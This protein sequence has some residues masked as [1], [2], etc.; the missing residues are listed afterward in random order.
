MLAIR[1]KLR[2]SAFIFLLVLLC[3]A[4][5]YSSQRNKQEPPGAAPEIG[6]LQSAAQIS[7]VQNEHNAF[8][9]TKSNGR[10]VS[11][12]NHT[13]ENGEHVIA[14]DCWENP[15]GRVWFDQEADGYGYQLRF[16]YSGK[17]LEPESE[18]NNAKLVQRTC[19]RGDFLR[20]LVSKDTQLW[21]IS[22]LAGG[23]FALV[24][25]DSGYAVTAVTENDGVS[26][27]YLGTF[28]QSN[29]Q[30]FSY[31]NKVTHA[32]DPKVMGMWGDLIS[33]PFVPIQA[34]ALYDDTVLSWSSNEKDS[35]TTLSSKSSWSSVFDVAT[36]TFLSSNNPTHDMFCSGSVLME[37]GSVLASGGNPRA[38]QTSGFDPLTK[39]WSSL[40]SMRQQRWYG[41]NVL[42][43]RG[44]VLSG[45]AKGAQETPELYTP[46]N[47]TWKDLP[48]A[49]MSAMRDE[50][51]AV[52]TDKSS[53]NFSASMQWY[54]FMHTSPDGRVF[55]SGPLTNFHW[56]STEQSGSTESAGSPPDTSI[57]RQYGSSVMY[58]V[59]KLL[60]SGG[61]DPRITGPIDSGDSEQ[62]LGATDTAYTVEISAASPTIKAVNS[63]HTRRANHDS[64]VLPTG[65]V[66]VV[67][68]SKSGVLF[69]DT[70]TAW[71]SEIWNPQ[72]EQWR[73]VAPISAPRGYHSWALLVRDGRVLAGGGGLCG[74]CPA[75]HSDAQFYYPP[76]LFA[77]NGQASNRPSILSATSAAKVGSTITVSVDSAISNLNLVRLSS[78]TH[79][80]NT[81]Q[82]FIPLAFEQS[83]ANQYVATLSS[84]T[85]V[86][87]PGM[88]WLF[89]V[90]AQG[91]PS[92]GHVLHIQSLAEHADPLLAL[93]GDSSTLELN[94]G[95]ALGIALASTGFDASTLVA[96]SIDLPA[97]LRLNQQTHMLEGNAEIE[98]EGSFILSVSDDS[99]QL[100]QR[101]NYKINAAT[102]SGSGGGDNK[103]SSSGSASGSGGSIGLWFLLLLAYPWVAQRHRNANS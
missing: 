101:I 56:Y 50:Q 75:N 65:E 85:N 80:I 37:D 15:R 71:W 5:F 102:K 87:I 94:K 41:T 7:I 95:D 14:G 89:A 10:C 28:T 58:D 19:N 49:D 61:S 82:R 69:N 47:N 2:L 57:T 99:K 8:I 96:S 67:G 78:T 73:E 18:N 60:V 63:M 13:R 38:D 59:G 68:G 6:A 86:L 62:V 1:N 12:A 20:P 36:G 77:N 84:N 25:V 44:E 53:A 24:H 100:T 27:L 32:S 90:D 76:Y 103:S 29:S 11:L 31:L 17:C 26:R 83:D 30:T 98:G 33:W 51:D 35:F 97:G 72:N 92:E 70:G 74:D 88:Y 22:P 34:A 79:S 9:K 23:E 40:S 42:T 4:L 46:S 45:F 55:N 81:D 48:G 54:A 16:K 64:V 91:V 66:F 93:I 43:G 52:N 21:N 39:T 3:F